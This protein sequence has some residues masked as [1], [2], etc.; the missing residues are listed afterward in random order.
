MSTASVSNTLF[1]RTYQLQETLFIVF[2]YFFVRFINNQKFVI[3]G[4]KLYLNIFVVFCMVFIAALTLLTGYYSVFFIGM[5]GLYIIYNNIQNTT[6]IQ[7]YIIIL[8]CALFLAQVFYPRYVLGFF[9]GRAIETVRTVLT[10]SFL[11]NI[12]S[13]VICIV[14]LINSHFF[15]VPVII[16]CIVLLLYLLFLKQKI[17]FKKLTLLLVLIPFVY[18]IIVTI[19]APYKDLRYSMSIFP[20]FVFLPAILI[21]SIKNKYILYATALLFCVVSSVNLFSN[22]IENLYKDRPK[23]YLFN[24]NKNIP[25]FVINK[26]LWLYADLVPYFNDEQVYIFCDTFDDIIVNDKYNNIYLVI[27]AGESQ[28]T[29]LSNYEVES[30]FNIDFFVC[31]KLRRTIEKQNP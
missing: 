20:F 4:N 10:D 8:V 5:F 3:I 31:R 29:I 16:L 27:E 24:E 15:T 14:T 2:A 18:T 23:Q 17:V 7:V 11:G 28:N 21:Y 19:V 30:E 25:V 26:T 6:E 13:S 9:S 22:K 12:M 1:F